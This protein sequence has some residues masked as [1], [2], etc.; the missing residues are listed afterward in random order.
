MQ[1]VRSDTWAKALS[2]RA[3]VSVNTKGKWVGSLVEAQEESG[4]SKSLDRDENRVARVVRSAVRTAHKPKTG[5][6]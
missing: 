2:S 5:A 3:E 4:A 6:R 1:K